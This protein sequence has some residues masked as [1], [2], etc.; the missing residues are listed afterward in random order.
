LISTSSTVEEALAHISKG[1]TNGRGLLEQAGRM[2]AEPRP[3]LD[4]PTPQNAYEAH[5]DE[6]EVGLAEFDREREPIEKRR[7]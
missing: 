6:L 5:L 4:A 2:R 1:A 7:R 3:S